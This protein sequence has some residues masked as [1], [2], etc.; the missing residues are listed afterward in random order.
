VSAKESWFD[1][2]SRMMTSVSVHDII[3]DV[4]WI[5]QRFQ[6]MH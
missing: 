2:R 3:R 6:E 5:F 1:S 4:L